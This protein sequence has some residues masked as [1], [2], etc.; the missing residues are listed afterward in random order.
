M[1]RNISINMTTRFFEAVFAAA[2][3]RDLFPPGRI[4]GKEVQAYAA[5]RPDFLQIK[6]RHFNASR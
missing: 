1:D 5:A 6:F 3:T 2:M 4:F